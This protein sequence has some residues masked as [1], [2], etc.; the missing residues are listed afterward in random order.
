MKTDE[1]KTVVITKGA[2]ILVCKDTETIEITFNGKAE[3]GRRFS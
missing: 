1:R 3:V 2:P